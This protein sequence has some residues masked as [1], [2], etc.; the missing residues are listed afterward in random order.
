ML[1]EYI[2]K[3]ESDHEGGLGFIVFIAG[4]AALAALFFAAK[5]S[6]SFVQNIKYY[7]QARE[8]QGV[9]IERIRVPRNRSAP[10][11]YLRYK[12]E[13]ETASRE[14]SVDFETKL[15]PKDRSCRVNVD[16]IEVSEA[17]YRATKIPGKITVLYLPYQDTSWSQVEGYTSRHTRSLI[18]AIILSFLGLFLGL[19]TI[20]TSRLLRQ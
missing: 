13:N 5:F 11:F 15:T 14:C 2:I 19:F 18:A 20:K 16:S 6:F 7:E 1:S 12:Y 3:T 17:A 4:V 9:L 8:T 10:L